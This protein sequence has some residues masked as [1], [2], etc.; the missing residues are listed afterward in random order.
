MKKPVFWSLVAAAGIL[1]AFLVAFQLWRGMNKAPIRV[2]VLPPGTV[3]GATLPQQEALPL[4]INTATAQQLQS[5]PGIGPVLAQRI[6]DDRQANGA[7]SSVAQLTRVNG[8][9]LALLND[10]MDYITV[11]G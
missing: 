5:L 6:V 2:T 10:I 1:A 9:G 3:S 7:F 4:N 11:G 8:I